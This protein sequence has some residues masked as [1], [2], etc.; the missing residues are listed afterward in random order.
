MATPGAENLRRRGRRNCLY[1]RAWSSGQS[2][3]EL[4]AIALYWLG[5]VFGIAS[6]C[7]AL[8]GYSFVSQASRDAVRYAVVR[9]SD[10]ASANQ[11]TQSS[12]QSFVLG[13]THGISISA[14]NITANWSTDGGTTWSATS[15]SN[16]KPG[17]LVKVTITYN[18]QPIY[19]LSSLTL[20]LTSSS[21]MVIT[22]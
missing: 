22:Y 4:A 7:L 10:V 8:Y 20:P 18:Y 13:E 6:A 15:A 2:T 16:N 17:N 5:L 11:A 12:V 19:P 14:S 3:L 21:Q 1:R 9:G